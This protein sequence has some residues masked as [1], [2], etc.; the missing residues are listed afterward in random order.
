MSKAFNVLD[1]FFGKNLDK[2]YLLDMTYITMNNTESIVS[3]K[4]NT[5]QPPHTAP[6]LALVKTLQDIV[7]DETDGTINI[8]GDTVKRWLARRG[9]DYVDFLA[10]IVQYVKDFRNDNK[11]E[12]F[13]TYGEEND[14]DYLEES[15]KV[16]DNVK[17]STPGNNFYNG[18][19]GVVDYVKDDIVTVTFDDKKSPKLNN[20]DLNQVSKITKSGSTKES[21]Y[22]YDYQ[23]V[24]A[25]P[26]D[27]V[28][29]GPYGKLYICKDLGDKYWVTDEESD[30]GNPN[31]QGWYIDKDLA[32]NI[33]Y[34]GNDFEDDDYFEESTITEDSDFDDFDIGPQSDE[35][36]DDTDFLNDEEDTT[37]H[38]VIAEYSDGSKVTYIYEGTVDGETALGRAERHM[39]N[40]KDIVAYTIDGKRTEKF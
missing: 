30:A 28:D 27:Y 38:K 23:P 36:E 2:Q 12:S 29:F 31:A 21:Y 32:R 4:A 3:A 26:G 11:T 18:R 37:P 19:T 40:S 5:H 24:D 7:T 17:V 25:Y 22:S 34:S 1:N 16:G 15:I 35:Y 9:I 8:T 33:I 6:W 39:K 20:F 14:D 10:P 13:G